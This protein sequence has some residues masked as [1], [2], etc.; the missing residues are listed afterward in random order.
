MNEEEA[1]CEQAAC[2][3]EQIER[4]KGWMDGKMEEKKEWGGGKGEAE[5]KTKNYADFY[6]SN[7]PKRLKNQLSWV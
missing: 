7:K 4:K 6:H 2:W 5:V 1:I 3:E